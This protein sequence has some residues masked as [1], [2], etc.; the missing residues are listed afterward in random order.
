VI[1]TGRTEPGVRLE[2]DGQRAPVE[3]DGTFSLSV[4]PRAEGLVD[5]VVS[6]V[7]ASGNRSEASQRVFIETL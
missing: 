7:D 5:V 4:T 3:A 6:A 1:I 2:I